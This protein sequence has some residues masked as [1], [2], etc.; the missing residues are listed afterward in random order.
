MKNLLNPISSALTIMLM[1]VAGVLMAQMT[2]MQYYR[3]NDA[4]GINVF[5]NF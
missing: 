3:Y 2:P 5:R 1:M 4:R